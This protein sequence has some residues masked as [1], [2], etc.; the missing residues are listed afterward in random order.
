[1]RRTAWLALG[2]LIGAS[3]TVWSR[4]R[5]EQLASRA[6]SGE[7][8]GDVVRLVDRGLRR[9]DRRLATAVSTGREE[10]RRRRRELHHLYGPRASAR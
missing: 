4:R 9:V 10:A 3:G 2:A 7:V 1:M 8:P 6:R 5:L